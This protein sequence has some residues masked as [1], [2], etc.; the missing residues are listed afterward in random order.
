MAQTPALVATLK[1][2]LKAHGKT[3]AHV[4]N[5]LDISEASVKRLFAEQ[6]FSLQRLEVICQSID[7]QLTDLFQLMQQEQ[8]QLRQLSDAQ[9]REI[10]ADITLLMVAVNVINGLKFDELLSELKLDASQCIQKL[11]QLDRLK[12]IDLLPNNRIKLRVAPNFRWLTNGPIQRFFHEKVEQYF[13]QS[14]FDKKEEKLLVLNGLLSKASNA[15]MQKKMQQLARDFNELMQQDMPLPLTE[16]FGTTTVLAIR[17]W[18]YELFQ[19]TMKKT[20]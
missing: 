16:R 7:L 1:R 8:P 5:T 2:Q 12:I 14:R 6:S 18:E 17:R 19:Q 10:V 20:S 3:Y 15:V 13:F 4:A 11:A 9:E